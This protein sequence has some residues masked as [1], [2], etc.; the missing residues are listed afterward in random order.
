MSLLPKVPGLKLENAAIDVENVSLT[1]AS[2]SVP[3]ACPVCG[4]NTSRLHSHYGRTMADL[5][6][7]GRRVRLFLNV[8]K[9]RCPQ[10]RCPRRVFTERLPDLVES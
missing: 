5:P 1:L 7:G 3:V 4:Q 6:W 2:T 9:F 8:R 10:K